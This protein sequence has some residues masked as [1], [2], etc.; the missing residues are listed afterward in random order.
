MSV[1][2]RHWGKR[3]ENEIIIKSDSMSDVKCPT[4][5]V[6]NGIVPKKEDLQYD[7]FLCDCGKTLWVKEPCGCAN[8]PHD[9]LRSKPN[10]NFNG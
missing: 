4:V 10:P 6:I 3:I 7:N 9:E 1:F 8:N 2:E 5:H